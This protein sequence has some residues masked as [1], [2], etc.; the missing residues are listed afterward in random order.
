MYVNVAMPIYER[1]TPAE[2]VGGEGHTRPTRGAAAPFLGK[3]ALASRHLAQHERLPA[4][5]RRLDHCRRRGG[6]DWPALE[7][8]DIGR[9][10]GRQLGR[11]SEW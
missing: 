8:K 7:P 3:D 9:Q 6:V 11:Q 4:R 10:L 2:H 1:E 5:V